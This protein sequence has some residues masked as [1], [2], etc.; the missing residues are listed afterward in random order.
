LTGY[1]ATGYR[2]TAI[3]S[4]TGYRAT[5]NFIDRL[6]SDGNLRGYCI[7]RLLGDWLSSD[8]QFHRPAIE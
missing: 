3:S 5:G 7:D 1:R 4:L 8:G 2:V 6:S